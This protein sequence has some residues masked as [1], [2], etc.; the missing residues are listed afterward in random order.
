M[1]YTYAMPGKYIYRVRATD[2]DGATTVWRDIITVGPNRK[3]Y[4][5]AAQFCKA[6]QAFWGDQ[7]A[8]RYG[9]GSHAYG[10]CVSSNK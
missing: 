6:E 2:D 3:D 7:F 4:K 10:K 1:Q 5:N 9:G 8:D